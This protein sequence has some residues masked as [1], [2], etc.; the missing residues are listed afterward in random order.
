MPYSPGVY[1]ACA[2]LLVSLSCLMTVIVLNLHF[3]GEFGKKL[4][5]W[6]RKIFL[7]CLGRLLHVKISDRHSLDKLKVRH[8][9]ATYDSRGTITPLER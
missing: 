8:T 9:C 7:H 3:K 6:A 5:S 1:F 2:M 4:P